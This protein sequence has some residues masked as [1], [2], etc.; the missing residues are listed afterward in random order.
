MVAGS[1][2]THVS[3]KPEGPS[4]LSARTGNK[5]FPTPLYHM[6]GRGEENQRPLGSGR[7]NIVLCGRPALVVDMVKRLRPSTPATG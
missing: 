6:R 1:G 2:S 5:G 3:R 4:K 7:L